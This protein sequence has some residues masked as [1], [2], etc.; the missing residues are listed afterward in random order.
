MKTLL[1][2]LFMVAL[3]PA[4]PTTPVNAGISWQFGG[5]KNPDYFTVYVIDQPGRVQTYKIAGQ[6]HGITVSLFSGK[7]YAVTVTATFNGVESGY[8]L[9]ATVLAA[10]IGKPPTQ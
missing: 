7:A 6:Y 9:P 1:A 3:A 10:P 2:L 8:S 5:P 4:A